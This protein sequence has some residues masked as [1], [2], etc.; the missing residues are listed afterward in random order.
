[1]AF[2]KKNN[3]LQ[4]WENEQYLVSY[5]VSELTGWKTIALVPLSEMATGLHFAQYSAVIVMAL[6]IV[7]ILI[8]VPFVAG[9]L[10]RPMIELKKRWKNC[11]QVTYPLGLK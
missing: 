1:M 8:A 5:S 2:I 3:T 10:T 6:L 11:K 9:R 4:V 7:A